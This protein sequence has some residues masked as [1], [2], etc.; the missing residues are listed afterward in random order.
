[1]Q[2]IIDGKKQGAGLYIDK[3]EGCLVITHD[4]ERITPMYEIADWVQY[5]INN[6]RAKDAPEDLKQLHA[7]F[8]TLWNK[9]I[10]QLTGSRHG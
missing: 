9:Y 6:S 2:T 4:K 3:M 1:M 5:L 7:T 8:L 10:S